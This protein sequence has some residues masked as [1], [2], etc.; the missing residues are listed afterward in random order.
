MGT[1][2]SQKAP[3][4]WYIRSNISVVE[5]MMI[6]QD[7]NSIA[8]AEAT[9]YHMI[10]NLVISKFRNITQG[11]KPSSKSALFNCRIIG[12]VINNQESHCISAFRPKSEKVSIYPN[13]THFLNCHRYSHQRTQLCNPWTSSNINLQILVENSSS[14]NQS[15]ISI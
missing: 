1:D 15:I 13:P 9:L 11:E 2:H 7:Q 3:Q 10:S 6:F 8:V 12:K 14:K 5:G 4:I